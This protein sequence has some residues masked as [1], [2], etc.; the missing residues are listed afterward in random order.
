MKKAEVSPLYKKQD[1]L[2]KKNYRPVSVLTSLSKVY[3][4]IINDQ[5]CVHFTDI[6]ENMVA[7]KL[8]SIILDHF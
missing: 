6:F 3:E 1:N 5:M 2:S 7:R 8:R 4:S